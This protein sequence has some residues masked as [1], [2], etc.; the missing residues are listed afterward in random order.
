MCFSQPSMPDP[1]EQ[2]KKSNAVLQNEQVAGTT[3]EK[4]SNKR[5]VSSLR[6][7][8]DKTNKT[9]NTGINTTD[10]TTGLNIPV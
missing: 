8:L 6:I 7:P 4:K 1:S 9:T 3:T 2:L 10:T 5:T